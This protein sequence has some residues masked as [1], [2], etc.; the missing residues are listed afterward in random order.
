MSWLVYLWD[1]RATLAV[2][3]SFFI[4]PLFSFPWSY[5]FPSFLPSPFAPGKNFSFTSSEVHFAVKGK[6]RIAMQKEKKN[7]GAK[8]VFPLE[9]KKRK[10]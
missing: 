5:A 9:E 6:G 4:P 2:F 3:L 1:R 10:W 8:K 7:E